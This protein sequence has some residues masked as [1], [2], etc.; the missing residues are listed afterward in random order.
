MIEYSSIIPLNGEIV[1]I[2]RGRIFHQLSMGR[3]IEHCHIQNKL[4][5]FMIVIPDKGQQV[6]NCLGTS[7]KE[8]WS[9]ENVINRFS[10]CLYHE[11]VS[12]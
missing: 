3:G 6:L 11:V 1:D 4:V 8:M 5:F 2:K 10:L 12:K 7:L 9:R